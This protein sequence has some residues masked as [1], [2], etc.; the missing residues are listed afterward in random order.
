MYPDRNYLSLVAFCFLFG[1]SV[2]VAQEIIP[3]W[4]KSLGPSEKDNPTLTMYAPDSGKANGTAIIICPGGSYR[5]LARHE[6]EDYALFLASYGVRAFVLKYRLGPVYGYREITADAARAIRMVRDGAQRWGVDPGRI[7]IMGSSAGGH[8]AATMMTHFDK[9]NAGSPDPIERTSSR[10]DFGILCYPVISMGPIGH[11]ISKEQFLG[12]N[13]A[14]E[15]ITLYSN[16]LQ[17][18]KETPPGFLW[19]TYEDSVVSVENSLMFAKALKEH[20][21]PFAL[22]VYEHG[23][24]GLGLAARPPFE[25]PHPWTRD[26]LVWLSARKL[27]Q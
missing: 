16:E 7:G 21:V 4:P 18:T 6:G 19:H 9:G 20:G 12:S 27:I 24:H 11:R 17:V 25:N 15:L 26:L 2:A 8:L 13:P 22:H 3:L 23:R 1:V 5:G 10:P 14:D